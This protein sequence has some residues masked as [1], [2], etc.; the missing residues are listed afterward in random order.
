MVGSASG[1]IDR[2]CEA[3]CSPR[4][5]VAVSRSI[6][7]LSKLSR[8]LDPDGY[9]FEGSTISLSLSLS[10]KYSA[11]SLDFMRL[12]EPAL[13]GLEETLRAK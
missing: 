7:T 13:E 12:V 10:L 8:R 1:E 4:G 5:L 6:M 11:L 2:P 9:S 3:S